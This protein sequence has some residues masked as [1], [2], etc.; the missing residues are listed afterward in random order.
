MK[1]PEDESRN[2]YLYIHTDDHRPAH[3]HVFKGRK[4]DG[5]RHNIKI[6]IGGENEPQSIVEADSDTPFPVKN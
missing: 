4:N 5:N 3:I 1:I 2:L 6:N